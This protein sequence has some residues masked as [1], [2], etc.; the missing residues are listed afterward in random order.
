V[1][2]EERRLPTLEVAEARIALALLRY[3]AT[4]ARLVLKE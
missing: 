4:I 1:E 2:K 3:K